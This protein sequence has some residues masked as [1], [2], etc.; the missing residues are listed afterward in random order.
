MQNSRADRNAHICLF[1]SLFMCLCSVYSPYFSCMSLCMYL[2]LFADTRFFSFVYGNAVRG[3]SALGD[4]LPERVLPL[5]TQQYASVSVTEASRLK[6]GEALLQVSQRAGEVLPNYGRIMHV[7]VYLPLLTRLCCA[8][9]LS[10]L[11][12]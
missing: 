11:T 6:I 5:L 10:P 7:L 4:I 8:F 12:S 9:S 3:L 2:L 1:F